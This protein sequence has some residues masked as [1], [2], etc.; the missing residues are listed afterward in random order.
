MR[1]YLSFVLVLLSIGLV[2]TLLELNIYPS[3][4]KAL[5]IERSYSL[6]M[7]IKEAILESLWQG[8]Q[9]GFDNYNL[10]HD[11]AMCI[12]CP[13]CHPK[14]C[15]PLRCQQCFRES[16]SRDAAKTHALISL[17]KLRLH[18]FDPDFDVSI[19][20][21]QLEVY[22]SP[23]P[24]SKNGFSLDSVKITNNIPILIN[25][26]KFD[27]YGEVHVPLGVIIHERSN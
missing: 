12:H 21:V 10:N 20:D 3:S 19:G 1:G 11:I 9:T 7:N 22:T 6:S 15:D 13:A 8:T 26:E 23:D 17:D 16:E 5:L 27:I 25:S 4:S 14:T 18:S 2:F 24:L